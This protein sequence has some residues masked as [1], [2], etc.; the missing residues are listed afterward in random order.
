[1]VKV[2][3]FSFGSI[4]L[5]GKKYARDVLLFPDGSVKKRKGGFWK[6]GSHAIKKR[7]IEE[8]A[9]TNPEVVIVGTGTVAK[10]E[11]E[12]D[13]ESFARESKPELVVLP[14]SEAIEELNKLLDKG[15]RVAA[16]IHITC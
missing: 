7:E 1:M 14:S 4:V 16:L 6:Y 13:A 9:D 15:K 8:L 5:D 2:D 12:P 3:S 11:L 10:A